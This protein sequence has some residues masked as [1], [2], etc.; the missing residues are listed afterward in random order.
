MQQKIVPYYLLKNCWLDFR[1]G[2][3]RENEYLQHEKNN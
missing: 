1:F 3:A 2:P